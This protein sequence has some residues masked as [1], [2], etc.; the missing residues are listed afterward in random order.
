[1]DPLFWA[2]A[3]KT[4][5]TS[6]TSRTFSSD[7]NTNGQEDD[8]G[9]FHQLGPTSIYGGGTFEDPMI[10]ID[11]TRSLSD[12]VTSYTGAYLLDKAQM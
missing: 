8:A 6:V 9:P 3:G 1:M 7:N 10:S 2:A 5:P 11:G 12:I 4:L